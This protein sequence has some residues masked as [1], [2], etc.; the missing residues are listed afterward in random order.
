MMTDIELAAYLEGL[1]LPEAGRKFVTRTRQSEPSRS[2]T[3]GCFKN[4]S[5]IIFSEK[6][7][8]TIQSESVTGE[9]P[10][11]Y[12]YELDPNVLEFWDQIPGEQIQGLDK[13]GK[14]TSW[15]IRSDFLVLGKS[16]VSIEEIKDDTFVKNRLDEKHPAWKQDESGEIHYLP[17]EKH[18][19][20]MGI[21]YRIRLV[22]SFNKK[23]MS[24]QK[25]LL[26]SRS[27]PKPTQAFSDKVEVILNKS[28]SM[29]MKELMDRLGVLDATSL[30]Q[31]VDMGVI[32]CELTEEFLHD[33]RNVHLSLSKR[34]SVLARSMRCQS[35]IAV[36]MVGV[37]VENIPSQK[38]AEEALKKLDAIEN[39]ATGR[40]ARRWLKKIKDGEL[41]GFTPFQ[42]LVPR[43]YLSGNR[44]ERFSLK[45]ILVFEEAVKKF[46]SNVNRASVTSAYR[47]YRQFAMQ[48]HPDEEPM[49]AEAFRIRIKK[50]NQEK[51]GFSRGGK[52]MMHARSPTSDVEL[53]SLKSKVAFQRA[54]IDH[55]IVKCFLIWGADSNE[56]YVDRP[57]LTLLIDE[58]NEKVLGYHLSFAKP[59]RMADACVLRDCVRRYGK[60]P[61][62]IVA[63]HGSDLKSAYFRSLLAS[64]KIAINF[65]PKSKSSA[66]SE[67]E[68]FFN[69]FQTQW[70]CQRQ[71]NMVDK[72]AVRAVDGKFSARQ[73]A[74]FKPEDFLLEFEQYLAYRDNK[75][76]GSKTQTAQS[77]FDE[78]TQV[79]GF[80][81][82]KIQYNERF[83]VASAVE[84]REFTIERNDIKIDGIRYSHPD[85]INR[86]ITKSKIEV[87]I[88][89][90][91]PYVVYACLNNRWISCTATGVVEFMAKSVVSQRVETLKIRGAGS[92]RQLAKEHSSGALAELLGV[93]DT[94]L[95]SI[96]KTRRIDIDEGGTPEKNEV[97][98]N[99]FE[100]LAQA[101]I[102]ELPTTYW[103]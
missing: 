97:N 33:Y 68:R 56:V 26:S 73:Q 89:P 24:N 4:G 103:R 84:S 88:E 101:D 96:H 49:S 38:Y 102:Y 48:E 87:R 85:L 65:R 74:A 82:R 11:I 92:L 18:F 21:R 59:S 30:I 1:S 54:H 79:Y 46:Y 57:W 17:A 9:T 91:N 72:H 98:P 77:A 45:I 14:Q 47:R 5:S 22:S 12:A 81:G 42:C 83:I 31:L 6:M 90:E 63:D 99:V 60:L 8:R 15:R 62:E 43:T 95:E 70:L 16:G 44:S 34:L 10:A 66:G 29:T 67:V 64:E 53:R 51:I 93:A 35:D 75:L 28:F 76:K 100:Q 52:R 36:N 94:R 50:M 80:V 27:E 55:H 2:V 39:G 19:A 20:K 71:G 37:S 23:L 32:F 3:E 86:N 69:E 61:E 78:S 25:L 7:G 40:S 13:N 41:Q 58:A